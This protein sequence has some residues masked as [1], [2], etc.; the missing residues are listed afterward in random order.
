MWRIERKAIKT[1]VAA[2][3]LLPAPVLLA[4]VPT[5]EDIKQ[6]ILP[7][8]M[9]REI[10]DI[11]MAEFDTSTEPQMV[12][13]VAVD[14]TAWGEPNCSEVSFRIY[15]RTTREIYARMFSSGDGEKSF[16]LLRAALADKQYA[17][18][19]KC[20]VKS[21]TIP[22][23][24]G[25]MQTIFKLAKDPSRGD[26]AFE[27]GLTNIGPIGSR[28]AWKAVAKATG[29]TVTFFDSRREFEERNGK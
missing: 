26:W 14:L 28:R 13:F 29:S 4:K 24:S 23:E 18:S 3:C 10:A 2:M 15:F 22:N 11:R 19:F 27:N 21:E 12:D 5:G 9:I 25:Q 1:I 6:Q 8:L 17:I 7:A 16:V 20:M